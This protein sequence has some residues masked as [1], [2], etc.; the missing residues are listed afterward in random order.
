[1]ALLERF[2]RE[3]RSKLPHYKMGAEGPVVV[4][5]T[6][7]VEVTRDLIECGLVEYGLDLS[8]KNFKVFGKLESGI[9]GGSIKARPAA[10]II[11][12]AI[13][14]GELRQQTRVF[15][16]TSGNFGI[17]LGLMGSLGLDVVALVSRKLKDGVR[18]ELRRAGVKTIILDVDLCPAPGMSADPSKVL[19]RAV[20]STIMDQLASDGF[21]VSVFEASR[22]HIEDLLARGD[23]IN[24]AKHLARIYG[25]FCTEQYDNEL[26]VVA[27]Q[28]LT[29]P[30]IDQQIRSVGDSLS[31]YEIVCTFGTGGTSTGLSRYVQGAF[32]RKSV[33][34]VF[35]LA[36]QDVAGIRDKKKTLGLRFYQPENYAREHEVD[37]DAAKPL[38]AFFLRKGYDIGESAALALY[39]TLQLVRDGSEHKFVVIL[40]DGIRKYGAEVEA[41]RETSLE[42]GANEVSSNPEAFGGVLWT[43]PVFVPS[44]EA[45]SLLASSLGFSN[46]KIVCADTD[47]VASFYTRREMPK[48]FREL[49]PRE[50]RRLLCVCVNGNTSLKVAQLLNEVGVEAV[51]LSG[52]LASLSMTKGVE[53]STLIQLPEE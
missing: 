35:P 40:A 15:E 39:A 41:E 53:A 45:V 12:G 33:H 7:L 36:D 25:G 38:L 37:Y 1:M 26:N 6:P 27:H 23:A 8:K 14:S 49:L 11:E 19:A 16:A 32:G 29:G 34:V 3:I 31:D 5:G 17:A 50:G 48:D 51:S 28:V 42:V 24:L 4:N 10:Q 22:G 2:N 30:E 52:G 9:L 44:E 20:A 13:V 43:H 21:D 18:E 47:D 46:D